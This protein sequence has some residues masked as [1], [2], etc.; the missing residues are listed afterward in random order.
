MAMNIDAA[1]KVK[2]ILKEYPWL[3]DE[4]PKYD[5]RLEIIKNPLARAAMGGM[6]LEGV[7]DK[8]GMNT[9]DIV[10]MLKNLIAEHK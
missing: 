3:V 4:L 6:S 2:D 10:S 1:S 9:E 7:A 8:A 5:S